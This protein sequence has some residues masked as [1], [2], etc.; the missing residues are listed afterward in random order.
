MMALQQAFPVPVSFKKEFKSRPRKAPLCCSYRLIMSVL[1]CFG[2]LLTFASRFN[3]SS[4]INCMVNQTAV[5]QLSGEELRKHWPKPNGSVYDFCREYHEHRANSSKGELVWPVIVQNII[6]ISFLCGYWTTQIPG[7]LLSQRLGGKQLFGWCMLVCGTITLFTPLAAHTSYLLVA[8]IRLTLGVCQGVIWP[9][10]MAV[11]SRW[12]PPEERHRLT[13]CCF[14]GAA[15]GI[16][17]IDYLSDFM[18]EHTKGGW[19]SV[20]FISGSL[21]VIW[22]LV[23]SLL[24]YDSPDENPHISVAELGYIE[25]SLWN[26]VP[27]TAQEDY[28]APWKSILTSSPYW[29]LVA[30]HVCSEFTLYALIIFIDIYLHQA[31]YFDTNKVRA[32][33]ALSYIG[34]FMTSVTS[35]IVYDFFLTQEMCSTTFQRKAGVSLATLI[36]AV[37]I[38]YCGF[39][40]CTRRFEATVLLM[41]A[42]ALI[43][44]QFG[45]G[46][47]NNFADIAPSHAAVMY[48][49]S[50]TFS[51]VSVIIASAL[52]KSIVYVTHHSHWRMILFLIAAIDVIGCVIFMVFGTADIEDWAKMPSGENTPSST[53]ISEVRARALHWTSQR[54]LQR[55]A[56]RVMKRSFEKGILG[57][58]KPGKSPTSALQ[59]RLRKSEMLVRPYGFGQFEMIVKP[60]KSSQSEM[61]VKPLRP[62]QPEMFDQ[63]LRSRNSAM[64]VQPNKTVRSEM[65]GQPIRPKKYE[66]TVQPNLPDKSEISV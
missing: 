63:P 7:G 49:M 46:Y 38:I 39:L 18:C 16:V 29:A 20:F 41:T 52:I 8:A 15:L 21:S 10:M 51:T 45:C 33:S 47:L 12:A 58:Y 23:W 65:V 53:I 59:K 26:V 43:G 6:Q 66:R 4:V 42:V 40:D 27:P 64:F 11:W 17:A 55:R 9:A 62:R 36:P 22:C 34:F 56:Q 44:L 5:S 25:N 57:L 13:G 2:F 3:L 32:I 28:R 54:T 37:V 60:H 31:E 48:G 35:G 30:V 14:G 1:S 19:E 50:S 24:A 61:F